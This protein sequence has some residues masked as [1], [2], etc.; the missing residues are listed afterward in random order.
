M[1][2]KILK[3]R[4]ARGK[5]GIDFSAMSSPSGNTGCMYSYASNMM[6][7]YVLVEQRQTY[8]STG[9]HYHLCVRCGHE[10]ALEDACIVEMEHQHDYRLFRGCSN[11]FYILRCNHLGCESLMRIFNPDSQTCTTEGK[12]HLEADADSN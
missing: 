11:G 9:C 4:V 5:Q 10:K 7:H 1:R 3:V 8:Q 6:H 2:C 12:R